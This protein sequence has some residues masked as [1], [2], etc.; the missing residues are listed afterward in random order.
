MNVGII[1]LPQVG[2]KTLFRLLVGQGALDHHTDPR[3]PA[4]GVAEVDD[5]R[6]D[7]L[8]E[9]YQ[10][11]KVTR[12]RFEFVL[13]PKMEENSVSDGAIFRDMGDVEA[14]C[15]VVRA[16]PD[17]SV[18]H[19]WGGPDPAREI[20]F[21][22]SELVLHDL[23]FIEKRLERIESTLGKKKD[24]RLARE[25]AL[26]ERF[27]DHLD[28][29]KPLRRLEIST[30]ES[31]VIRSYPLLTLRQTIVALNV[32]DDQLSDDSLVADLESRFESLS[33]VR[34]AARA[35]AD[36]AELETDEERREFMND[37]GITDTARHVLTARCI[38]A[39]GYNSFFTVGKTEV[40][41]W[42]FRHG[43]LAPQ[44]AGVIH[45]DM[46]R[47]FIRV[48]VMKYA[49]LAGYGSEEALKAA[50]KYYVKGK[51]YAVEDG[52]ILSVRFNV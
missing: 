52:D 23:M 50:G 10:P 26:M 24:D 29:E 27:K 20:E 38:E 37:I 21:V 39:V 16:F 31:A 44:V 28:A 18:Y 12:A 8:V 1:G 30:E 36:I 14:L 19:M 13:L 45:S 43:A 2:K 51:D 32:S 15:H 17:D 4:R 22:Q 49:D 3:Q 46:E 33:F 25:K 35:E 42:F 47:G 41:H 11:R 7:H 40:H 34:I 6:F 48:E 5:K 9:M